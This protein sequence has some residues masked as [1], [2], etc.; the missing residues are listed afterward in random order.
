MAKM[1][2]KFII[3]GWILF[4]CHLEEIKQEPP[5]M[6]VWNDTILVLIL[7]ILSRYLFARWVANFA[8]KKYVKIIAYPNF[9][10][11]TSFK[12]TKDQ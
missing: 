1:F 5:T 9:F 11:W 4:I 2:K 10:L 8:D 3:S 12:A 6:C 7:L